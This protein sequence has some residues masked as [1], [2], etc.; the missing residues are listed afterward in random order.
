MS[1]LYQLSSIK[2]ERREQGNR[3]VASLI[4]ENPELINEV[5]K[6]FH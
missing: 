4:N 1:L 6:I 2:N 5:T 3:T